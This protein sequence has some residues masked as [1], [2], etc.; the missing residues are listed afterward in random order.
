MVLAESCDSLHIILTASASDSYQMCISQ[1]I[2]KHV[3]K[4]TK[5]YSNDAQIIYG[6]SKRW[7]N[8][9]PVNWKFFW[10]VHTLFLWKMTSLHWNAMGI[11]KWV[12]CCEGRVLE[13]WSPGVRARRCTVASQGDNSV[14]TGPLF[15]VIAPTIGLSPSWKRLIALSQWNYLWTHYAKRHLNIRGEIGMPIFKDHNKKAIGIFANQIP[16][17]AAQCAVVSCI[18]VTGGDH[19]QSSTL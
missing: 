13:S 19:W 6:T 15:Y 7:T 17:T 2:G 3:L 11:Q 9:P 18:L 4:W 1:N 16:R 10:K 14:L 12:K 8:W 5:I